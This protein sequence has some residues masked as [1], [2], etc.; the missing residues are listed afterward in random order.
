[1]KFLFHFATLVSACLAMYL[2]AGQQPLQSN[3]DFETLVESTIPAGVACGPRQY[4]GTDI[5][6]AANPAL[7]LQNDPGKEMRNLLLYFHFLK[8]SKDA[9]K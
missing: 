8:Q 2:P 9:H 4:T 1:M 6:K 3:D 7:H 5:E